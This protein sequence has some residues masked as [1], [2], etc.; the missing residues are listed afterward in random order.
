MPRLIT[1]SRAARLVGVKRGVLQKRIQQGDL[2][3][4]EGEL[5]LSDLLHAYPQTEIEDTTM[6][7]RVETIMENAVNKIIRPD[8]ESP[9]TNTLAAR[10]LSLGQELAEARAEARRSGDIIA[11]LKRRFEEMSSADEKTQQQAFSTLRDWFYQTLESL[12]TD[13]DDSGLVATEAF[14]RVIR[15]Q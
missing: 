11:S 15:V 8:E 2:R 9:D 13:D 7:E 12:D 4:F 10:I 6:L 3:T 1:L 14:L 5:L